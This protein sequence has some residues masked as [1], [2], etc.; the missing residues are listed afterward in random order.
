L[1]GLVLLTFIFWPFIRSIFSS[2]GNSKTLNLGQTSLEREPSFK[3]ESPPKLEN[4]NTKICVQCGNSV[5]ETR[6]WCRDCSGTTFSSPK[7]ETFKTPKTSEEAIADYFTP[8]A[9][10]KEVSSPVSKVCPMC[11]E[12][13]KYQAK[14]CRFCRYEFSGNE[15]RKSDTTPIVESDF[16]GLVSGQ[17]D[18]FK[19]NATS[20][21]IG[22]GLLAVI[23]TAVALSKINPP[24][25][26]D[27]SSGSSSSSSTSAHSDSEASTPTS[28][29]TNVVHKGFDG[30]FVGATN[31]TRFGP[32]QVQLTVQSGKIIDVKALQFPN[33]D[34]RSSSI[35]SQAIPY[36]VNQTLSAQSDQ[37]SGV[38][39]ASYTSYGFY[40]SLQSALKKAGL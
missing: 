36:L 6:S 19:R 15:L 23:G 28:T 27:I 29:P 18:F 5:P 14:I 12:E 7:V 11:A 3:V 1:G 32:V 25:N 10:G 40:I 31:Q 37:I 24:S 38:G 21:Y 30:D 9:E 22:T 16:S 35:S 17:Q 39:G 2:W 13:I 33:G 26:G 34:A 20:I 8:S 4:A